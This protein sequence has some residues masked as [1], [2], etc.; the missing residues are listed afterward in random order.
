MI[1]LHGPIVSMCKILEFETTR[2]E[3]TADY[4]LKNYKIE[5][6]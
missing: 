2:F 3:T 4:K 5:K 1:V 6:L